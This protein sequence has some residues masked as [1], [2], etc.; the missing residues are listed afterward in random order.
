VR[1]RDPYGS[2][3]ISSE[4]ESLLVAENGLRFRTGPFFAVS[5]GD[6]NGPFASPMSSDLAL[7]DGDLISP[8]FFVFK[9][10]GEFLRVV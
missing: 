10:C 7:L 8:R 5:V 2:N 1:A 9:W 6:A 4:P 3:L